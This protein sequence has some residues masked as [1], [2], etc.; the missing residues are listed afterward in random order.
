MPRFF[1]A[2]LIL[3]FLGFFLHSNAQPRTDTLLNDSMKLDSLPLQSTV[4]PDSLREH[5]VSYASVMDKWSRENIFIN[6]TGPPMGMPTREFRSQGKEFLF[7]LLFLIVLLLG[8][9]KTFYNGYFNNLFRVFFNTSLRQNQLTDQLQQ[10][11]LPSLILNIFFTIVIGT[12]LWLSFSFFYP[13]STVTGKSLLL[14]C[15]GGVG[16]LYLIKFISL[17]FLGWLY[18]LQDVMNNYI[19]IIF[20]INKILAIILLPLV[21]VFAFTQAPF[22]KYINIICIMVIGLFFLTRY[23]KTYSSLDRRV[24]MNVFH[25]LLY[26]LATEIIPLAIVYKVTVDYLI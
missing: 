10:A 8:L 6:T 3:L 9:F 24:S 25:F 20:L 7:Y 5:Y 15:V 13:G 18:T 1:R 16:I 26:V 21:V 14:L 12:Y 11:T 19:F 23:M 22:V 17:K 2:S 4:L